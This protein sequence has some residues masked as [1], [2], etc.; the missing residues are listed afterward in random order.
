[1]DVFGVNVNCGSVVIDSCKDLGIPWG[2]DWTFEMLLGDLVDAAQSLVKY[3]V[4]YASAELSDNL[5]KAVNALRCALTNLGTNAWNIIAAAY[6]LLVGVGQEKVV[7]EYLDIGYEYICTCQEDAKS[8]IE[9]FGPAPDDGRAGYLLSSCSESGAVKKGDAQVKQQERRAA[10]AAA[11]EATKKQDELANLEQQKA[12]ELGALTSVKGYQAQLEQKQN[13]AFR[14]YQKEASRLEDQATVTEAEKSELERLQMIYEATKAAKQKIILGD[15]SAR[16]GDAK[17][18]SGLG[19]LST[20]A[21]DAADRQQALAK[22]MQEFPGDE[23]TSLALTAAETEMHLIQ[24]ELDRMASSGEVSVRETE[25]IKELA[26]TAREQEAY[27]RLYAE[28][29]P[30]ARGGNELEFEM[31]FAA[32]EAQFDSIETDYNWAVECL[33]KADCAAENKPD[34]DGLEVEF[35]SAL[36]DFNAALDVQFDVVEAVGQE[37]LIPEVTLTEDEEE[38]LRIPVKAARDAEGGNATIEDLLKGLFDS[39]TGG[40]TALGKDKENRD[41]Q[42]NLGRARTV[43]DFVKKYA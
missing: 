36:L 12:D 1:M 17:K 26:Q 33:K 34:V 10:Q 8:I 30:I 20:V 18:N 27:N 6:W 14:A 39:V 9:S 4:Q 23:E 3:G 19:G 31:Y 5:L 2:E 15:V 37:Q 38:D 25:S 42:T 32:L 29:L 24:Q 35:E 28:A 40:E 21:S 16:L 7:K 43:Y 41:V 22:K 11:K 13:E